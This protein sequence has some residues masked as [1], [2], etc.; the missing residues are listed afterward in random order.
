MPDQ[1]RRLPATLPVGSY[2][3]NND[4]VAGGPVGYPEGN[5]GYQ[6]LDPAHVVRLIRTADRRLHPGMVNRG[7]RVDDIEQPLVVEAR[8]GPHIPAH[9]P[10]RIR[11]SL[12][13]FLARFP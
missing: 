4:V 2:S 1:L 9:E 13:P 6:G 8:P 10:L 11:H 5:V 3:M 7:V 12:P